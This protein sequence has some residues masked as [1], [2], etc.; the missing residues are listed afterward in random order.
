MS[1]LTAVYYGICVLRNINSLLF[2]LV[3]ESCK[4]CRCILSTR[5]LMHKAKC[6]SLGN[7]ASSSGFGCRKILRIILQQRNGHCGLISIHSHTVI[8]MCIQRR[9]SEVKN[10]SQLASRMQLLASLSSRFTSKIKL[11]PLRMPAR[12]VITLQKG[13]DQVELEA[14]FKHKKVRSK[15]TRGR[16]RSRT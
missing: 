8:R 15:P 7:N 12:Q 5:L 14:N 9:Y 16:V 1:T 4:Y 6:V 2:H 10:I 13:R 11:N 3:L